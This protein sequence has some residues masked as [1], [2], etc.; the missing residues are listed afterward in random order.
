MTTQGTPSSEIIFFATVVLPDAL[1][2]HRP[3][4]KGTQANIGKG[5]KAR[6]R[7]DK[8]GSNRTGTSEQWRKDK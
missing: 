2:P 6:K 1:P 3:A 5:D 4:R 7:F 8:I